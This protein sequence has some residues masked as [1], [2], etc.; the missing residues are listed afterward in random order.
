MSEKSVD[1]VVDPR[2]AVYECPGVADALG[3]FRPC[4]LRAVVTE[5]GEDGWDG[6]YHCAKMMRVGRVSEVEV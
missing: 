4:G 6:P 2:D 3:K 1:P 5:T